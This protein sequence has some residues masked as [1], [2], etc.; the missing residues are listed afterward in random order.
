MRSDQA[1]GSDEQVIEEVRNGNVDAFATLVDKYEG[2]VFMIVRAHIPNDAVEDVAQDVFVRAYQ[3]LAS[4]AGKSPFEHWLAG[5]A[6]RTCYDYWRKKY[7]NREHLASSSTPEQTE[8]MEQVLATESRSRY[9]ELTRREE[10]VELL[11]RALGSL[12]AAD[13]SVLTLVHIQGHSVREAAALLGFSVINVK[14]RLHRA[15]RKLRQ[16]VEELLVSRGAS[17]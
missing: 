11:Q 8:W 3:A 16:S 10:A 2:R 12:P 17:S 9:D 7:R 15:R 13:R 5:I 6:T 14:V 1:S 4:F